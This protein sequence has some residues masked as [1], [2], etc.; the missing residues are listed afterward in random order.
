MAP[1]CSTHPDRAA[2]Y[3]CDG[4]GRLLCADCVEQMHKLVV[5]RHCR[6]RA[7]P[8]PASVPAA[9]PLLPLAGGQTTYG[10]GEAFAYPFRGQGGLL[11]WVVLGILV[12]LCVGT[13]IPGLWWVGW[14]WCGVVGLM[15][16]LLCAIVRDTAKGSNELPDWPDYTNGEDRSRE[17]LGVTLVSIIGV[18]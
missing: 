4:C 1:M 8:I 3:Q 13:A 16:G 15:P 9:S 5:C 17:W 11:F 6:E 7:L 12:V 10:L 14:F 2:V 18:L